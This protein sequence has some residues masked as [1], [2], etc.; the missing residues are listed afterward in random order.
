[1]RSLRA[2]ADSLNS[3]KR[4]AAP[5]TLGNSNPSTRQRKRKRPQENASIASSASTSLPPSP[6]LVIQDDDDNIDYSRANKQIFHTTG[7]NVLQAGELAS[8]SSL[9]DL[10]VVALGADQLEH[11]LIQQAQ[12][13]TSSVLDNE[14]VVAEEET[15]SAQHKQTKRK[16]DN[17]D[18][19]AMDNVMCHYMAQIDICNLQLIAEANGSDGNN[20]SSGGLHL[21][22]FQHQMLLAKVD[23]LQKLIDEEEA[24]EEQR[25][26]QP[27]PTQQQLE[28]QSLPSERLLAEWDLKTNGRRPTTQKNR[29]SATY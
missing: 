15:L 8:L 18:L 12:D 28:L 16:T 25:K 9:S 21:S 2:L 26:I 29:A 3:G 7:N 19:Q 1:M 10:G 22:K 23:I 6:P 24:K 5:S 4:D 27:L 14:D 20:E 13:H 17:I 11:N